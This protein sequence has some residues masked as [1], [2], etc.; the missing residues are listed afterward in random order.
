MAL[1]VLNYD[2]PLFFFFLFFSIVNKLLIYNALA[3][4]GM[5]L[6]SLPGLGR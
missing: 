6:A 2:Y 1:L 4:K 5:T 3:S